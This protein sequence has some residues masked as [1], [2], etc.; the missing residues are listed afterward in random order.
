M[1]SKLVEQARNADMIVFLG[2]HCGF[3]F[4]TKRGAYRC[5]QHPSLAVKNDRLSWYWHSKGIGGFGSI[6]FL[7]KIEQMPFRQ[8]VEVVM[9]IPCSA[10][11]ST[12]TMGSQNATPSAT[13]PPITLFLPEKAGIPLRLYD[14][15]CVRRGIS[16][17]IVD[18]LLRDGK[19][20]EDR[21]GNVVFVAYD[22]K[23]K[24]RFACVRGTYDN[25]V[26]RMDCV[27]SDKRYGFST[28]ASAPSDRLYVYESAI[29]LMSH[30]SLENA[31]TGDTGA[32][33]RHN[34]LSLAGTSDVALSFFLNQH[35]EVKE[36]VFCLDND[37]PGREAS[38]VM[39]KKY[40][41]MG[42]LT[43]IELPSA[44]DY[45]EDLAAQS[46]E[47]LSLSRIKANRYELNRQH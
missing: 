1:N 41:D 18:S 12:S 5:K 2:K 25:K 4:S 47:S 46:A 9:G 39:A 40:A 35:N 14:Y 17:H 32:W 36:L 21:R 33:R 42:Y 19:I 37:E 7:T 24:P 43:Q 26:F 23:N 22:D 10:V 11:H 44:K 8:A 13:S 29:D 30:G 27:G 15:L 45:N 3:T 28:E 6:D 38:G 16:R 34:R 31:A 20:Y